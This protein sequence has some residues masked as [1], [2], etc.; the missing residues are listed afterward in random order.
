MTRDEVQQESVNLINSHNNVILRWG[1]GIGKS[2]AFIKMQEALNVKKVYIVVAETAHIDNWRNDYIKHGKQSLLDNVEIFCYASLKKY[3]N[4]TVDMICLDEGH[5]VITDIRI[6]LLKSIKTTK[7]VLLSA[8]LR[9]VQIKILELN[10]GK[11][12]EHTISL[13]QAISNN[14]LPEPIIYLIPLELS[15]EK[16]TSFIFTR[17]NSKK[18]K[19]I[20]CVYKDRYKYI[21]NNTHYPD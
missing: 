16:T 8:T 21:T 3:I 1:T 19:E 7:R 14:M 4:T 11:F 17:G 20:N 13:K 9:P 15:N 2:L 6:D 18:R 10:I 5:H 12:Y